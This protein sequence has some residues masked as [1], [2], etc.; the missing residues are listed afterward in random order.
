MNQVHF[1]FIS[2]IYSQSDDKCFIG[3]SIQHIY[4]YVSNETK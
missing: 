2:E 4:R 1:I 3:I